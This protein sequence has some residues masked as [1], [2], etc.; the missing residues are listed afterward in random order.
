M[1]RYSV[2]LIL[3]ITF[4]PCVIG[5]Q[6]Q[7]VLNVNQKQIHDF[8]ILLEN[9]SIV[10][11]IVV[12]LDKSKL[13]YRMLENGKIEHLHKDVFKIS[14]LIFRVKACHA[15]VS[16][17]NEYTTSIPC[18]YRSSSSKS[19]LQDEYNSSVWYD[20]KVA[21]VDLK[22]RLDKVGIEYRHSNNGDIEYHNKDKKKVKIIID[23]MIACQYGKNK[24]S[25]KSSHNN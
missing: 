24:S 20:D 25:C 1:N 9:K 6:D 14:R 23:R 8:G 11:K 15:Y 2:L 21:M 10:N 13:E 7:P 5:A 22:M 3:A 4:S 17:E 19:A 12:E 18:N 16:Y